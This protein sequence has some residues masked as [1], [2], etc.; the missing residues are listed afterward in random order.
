MNLNYLFHRAV[1]PVDL[2]G[3]MTKIQQ[4]HIQGSI[5]L[6]I[7]NIHDTYTA[8]IRERDNTSNCIKNIDTTWSRQKTNMRIGEFI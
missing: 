6:I 1:F 4:S 7:T 2:T 8:D 3:N 5:S